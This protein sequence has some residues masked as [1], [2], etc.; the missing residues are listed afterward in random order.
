MKVVEFVVSGILLLALFVAG[1]YALEF[2]GLWY[3]NSSGHGADGTVLSW[4]AILIFT[5]WTYFPRRENP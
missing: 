5:A 3:H 1:L 2:L 4:A